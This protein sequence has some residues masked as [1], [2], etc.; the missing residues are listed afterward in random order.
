LLALLACHFQLVLLP[1][2]RSFYPLQVMAFVFL[3]YCSKVF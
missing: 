2:S 1:W 3:H